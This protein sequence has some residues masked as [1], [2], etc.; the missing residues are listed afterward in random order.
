MPAF[1]C[2]RLHDTLRGQPPE[3]LDE[4]IDIEDQVPSVYGPVDRGDFVAKLYVS[5]GDQH[6]PGWAGFVRQGFAERDR[7]WAAND[8]ED[9]GIPLPW[10]SSVGAAIVLRLMPERQVFAFTF[11]TTGRFLLKHEAWQ[12]GYGLQTALNLIYPR[13]GG[14]GGGRLV[15][16]DAKRRGEEIVRSRQQA[17]RA[18]KLETF[19]VDKIRDL[20][21]GA[22]GEPYER[23]WGKRISGT[24]AL[25]F[26]SDCAFDQ[27]GR[28]CRDLAYSHD[29]DDYKDRFAWLDA[30]RPIPRVACRYPAASRNRDAGRSSDELGSR[31]A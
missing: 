23:R 10:I 2:Y 25:S 6:P 3:D 28:L 14:A 13:A 29:R 24:D 26:A 15:A 22:T 27:L 18:T 12:R 16:V 11:G 5:T 1:T 31:S 9:S 7:G 19:D 17:T 20:V 8:Q 4:Y 21:G 30:I